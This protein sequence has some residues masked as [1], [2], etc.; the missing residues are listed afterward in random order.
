VGD[1]VVLPFHPTAHNSSSGVDFFMVDAGP[2]VFRDADLVAAH[3]IA[4]RRK[5]QSLRTTKLG[6]GRHIE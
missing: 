3:G 5:I 2:R 4:D 1:R 6:D